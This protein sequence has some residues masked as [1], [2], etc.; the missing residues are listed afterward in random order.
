MTDGEKI[1]WLKKG[2]Y[3]WYNDP[4]AK[5]YVEARGVCTYCGEDV[6]ASPAGFW[7]SGIDHVLPTATYPQLELEPLNCVYC[8]RRCNSKKGRMDPLEH[9]KQNGEDVSDPLKLLRERRS[10]IIGFVKPWL[11][12]KRSRDAEEY[13]KTT[14]LIRDC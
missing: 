11:K 12:E 14:A 6:F 13:E 10:E 5:A 7:S 3:N 9:W 1:Q 8:C 4:T 2:V